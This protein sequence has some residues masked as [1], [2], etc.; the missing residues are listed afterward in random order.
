MS[1]AANKTIHHRLFQTINNTDILATI[2][3]NVN[4]D[5]ESHL[6]RYVNKRLH[7]EQSN[8]RK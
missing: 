5:L 6:V 4:I 2:Y 7:Y 3:E 8:R 1:R